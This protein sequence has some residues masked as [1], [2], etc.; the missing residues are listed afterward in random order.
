MMIIKS[1]HSR[2]IAPILGAHNA[3]VRA[4]IFINKISPILKKNVKF[5]LSVNKALDYCLD[6]M[7]VY[8]QDRFEINVESVIEN[9]VHFIL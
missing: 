3:V 9:V 2:A 6:H 4:I 7:K 8:C 5:R 1:L